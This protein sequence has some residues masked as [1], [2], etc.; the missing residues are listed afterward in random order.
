MLYMYDESVG[1]NIPDNITKIVFAYR[2]NN[3][4]DKLP[5][6]PFIMTN[7]NNYILIN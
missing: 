7:K 3:T 6:N 2:F 1:D 4:V 5:Q